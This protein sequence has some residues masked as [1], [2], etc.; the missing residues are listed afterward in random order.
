MGLWKLTLLLL[1]MVFIGT[2]VKA[3]SVLESR[4]GY[5]RGENR[6][7]GLVSRGS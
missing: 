5:F 3:L 2:K 6:R 4:E 7:R 1:L